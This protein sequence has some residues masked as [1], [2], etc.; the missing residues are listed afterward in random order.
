VDSELAQATSTYGHWLDNG[1]GDIYNTNAGNIGIGTSSPSVK[2][3]VA[4][5]IQVDS[6]NDIC[7]K[8]GTCLS[9]LLSG[10][11]QRTAEGTGE[12]SASCIGNEKIVNASVKFESGYQSNFA[13]INIDY[14]NDTAGVDCQG[15]SCTLF[16]LCT[17][18]SS[19]TLGDWDK[20]DNDLYYSSG[21]IGIGTDV[22]DYT[23]DVQGTGYF[24]QPVTV[25]TPV[26]DTHAATK[27]YVDNTV[28]SATTTGIWETNGDD[29]YNANTGN[30]GI[31]TVSP[32]NKLDVS[33]DASIS[34]NVGIGT[35]S[36]SVALSVAGYGNFE[37]P[38]TV[39]TPVN[40]TH[41]TTKSYVDSELQSAT[42]TVEDTY[43][44][45]AGDTMT[46]TLDMN[47]NNLALNGGFLSGDGDNE[48]VYVSN[49]GTV[50]IATTSADYAFQI[51]GD[52]AVSGALMTKGGV[53]DENGNKILW[54]NG[55]CP[56]P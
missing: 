15:S 53:A 8:D 3:E 30:V 29:I 24:A 9:D 33:G 2:L 48:G 13:D 43:V 23:L 10:F 40:D 4:G 26:N 32:S 37:Q 46:G 17:P 42:T 39:G 54:C 7:I 35:S 51:E 16:I 55:N 5:D 25:G 18:G 52:A 19:A 12:I 38:V 45:E 11:T 31:G 20:I 22:I 47:G 56:T 49:T 1:S 28:S 27:N 41:A 50:G 6:A 36:P 14:L 44:N 34:G 21:N